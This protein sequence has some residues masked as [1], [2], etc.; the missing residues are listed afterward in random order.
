MRGVKVE[1]RVNW[2][3]MVLAKRVFRERNEENWCDLL[4]FMQVRNLIMSNPCYPIS[5]AGFQ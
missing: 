1:K 3:G 2:W 5:R 4:E